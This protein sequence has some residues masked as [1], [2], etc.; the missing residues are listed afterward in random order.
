MDIH[1][2]NSENFSVEDVVRAHMEDLA[3]QDKFGV[4][5]LKYWVNEDAKTIFCLMRGPDKEA[6]N[7]VHKQSHGD[8]ACNIIEVSDNEYDLFMGMGTAVNDL[9]YTNAGEIDTGYRTLLLLDAVFLSVERQSNLERVEKLIEAHNG[10]LIPEP[11]DNLMISFISAS[12]A[13]RFAQETD[14][15]LNEQGSDVAFCMAI[16]SGRPVDEEG[17]H[18]FEETKKKVRTLS[19]LG[20]SGKTHLDRETKLLFEKESQSASTIPAS[21]GIITKEELALASQLISALKQHS[22][23]P[24]FRSED[25]YGV[26][27]LSKSQAYRKIKALTSFAPNQLIQEFRAQK[28]IESMTSGERAISEIA[29]DSGFSSPTYFTRS[30]RKR[31]GLSPTDFTRRLA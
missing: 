27:G 1:T 14:Q 10:V 12:D 2:V 26:L 21:V 11:D 20:Y 19:Q 13:I 7:E 4:T 25:L 5:Q 9:A 3:I 16:S 30:F 8:T 29:Y 22:S 24:D 28:A 18:M 23:Q 17:D 31:F 15:F 6:C